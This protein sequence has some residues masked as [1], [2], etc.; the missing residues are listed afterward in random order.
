MAIRTIKQGTLEYLVAENIP[1][2]HCF[3]TRFGGVSVGH[4]DSLNLGMH[5]GDDPE[6]VAKNH[7]ILATALGFSAKKIILTHQVHSDVVRIVTEKDRQGFDHHQY[8]QCDALITN[9]SGVALMVFTADC[10]PILLH[11]P[12]TGAVGA[13]HA[14][15]RGTAMD[16]VGKTVRTMQAAFGCDP[17]NIRAAIGPNIGACCFETDGEV[18][19]AM[20]ETF[21][22]AAEKWIRPQ[23]SKYYV[24]LKEINRLALTRTGVENVEISGDCTVCQC[25]RFWS[26]R[27]TGGVRGAQGAVILCK[28]REK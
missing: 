17:Q 21:G 27:V 6:N 1:V 9:T 18:P 15:W 24:N 22:A 8:P 19:A 13:V 28:E 2:P 11:D 20:V 3:T 4:W 7:E 10:T 16:I 14:G 12:V 5:R 23:K 26:H 25:H